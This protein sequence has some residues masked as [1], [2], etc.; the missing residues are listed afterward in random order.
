[1]TTFTFF[2][3]PEEYYKGW[4]LKS[5]LNKTNQTAFKIVSLA[6]A[7]VLFAI[8][9]TASYGAS[10]IFTACLLA[11]FP[12][13]ASVMQKKTIMSE[14]SMSSVLNGEHS[15]KIYDEGIEFIGSFEKIFS[16]WKGVAAAKNTADYLTIIPDR[17]NTPFVINKN[18]FGGEELN[19]II[20]VL[21]KNQVISEGKND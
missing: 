4:K 14:F 19:R 6:G 11:A 16:T 9:F 20:D 15:I 2:M 10:F 12:I 8:S 5:K 21:Q 18:R 3:T 1:M 13:L 17:K 7:V